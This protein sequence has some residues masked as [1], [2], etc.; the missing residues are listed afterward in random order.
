MNDERNVEEKRE[1][2]EWID[3]K[4]EI[5]TLPPNTPKNNTDVHY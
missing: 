1:K 5:E 3:L 4:Q 2:G